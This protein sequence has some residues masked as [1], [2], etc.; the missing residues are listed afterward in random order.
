MT[1]AD[2]VLAGLILVTFAGLAA[3]IIRDPGGFTPDG[4]GSAGRRRVTAVTLAATVLV[5]VPAAAAVVVTAPNA[6]AAYMGVPVTVPGDTVRHPCVTEDASPV[7]GCVWDAMHR[8][9]G[10]GRSFVVRPS[11]RVV[12]VTH[13]RAH[14]LLHR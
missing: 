6:H 10:I 14:A 4:T 13:A 9:N 12:Y 2:A 3:F 11:G 7:G 1:A 8:G 5:A